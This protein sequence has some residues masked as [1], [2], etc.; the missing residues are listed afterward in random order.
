[1][2]CFPAR[3]LNVIN[4]GVYENENILNSKNIKEKLNT[5]NINKENANNQVA[6]NPDDIL[7]VNNNSPNSKTVKNNNSKS[8]EK[9]IEAESKNISQLR[10]FKV[11]NGIMV[12][13]LG[14][15]PFKFYEKLKVLGEGS[16]GTVFKV[17]HKPTGFIRAM[18]IIDKKSAALSDESEKTLINE[19]IILKSLDHPNI[20]KVNEYFNTK[21]K[22]YI[23]SELCTGGELFDKIQQEKIFTEK[24]AAHVMKQ[25]LSAVYYCHSN[26]V[27]HRDL[28]PE[29]ILIESEKEAKKE[30]FQ[31][32]IIDFGTSDVI[33]KN[34][35]LTKQIG[36][37]YYI[38][39]EILN[40]SYN[41]K[42]DLWSCGVILYIMLCGTPP[43][44][45]EDDED[46]YNLVK[47]GKYDLSG[48]EWSDVSTEAKDL[49]RNLLIKDIN[50]RFSAEQA[51]N[52]EWF[53][54]MESKI[55]LHNNQNPANKITDNKIL[56]VAKN[57]KVYKH[58]NKK[59]QQATLAYIVHNMLKKEETE[60]F[61]KI[62]LEFD[63]NG[64]GRLTKEELILGLSKVMTPEEAKNEVD[65]VM[66][67]IDVD[68]NGFIEYEEFLRAAM[69][70]ERILTEDNLKTVFNLFDKDHSGKISIAEIR[71]VLGGDV[72]IPDEIWTEI[73]C[74]IDKNGDGEISFKE[75]KEMMNKLVD[76]Q[77]LPRKAKQMMKGKLAF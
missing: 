57:L 15:D 38:A 51:L 49:I 43:F 64:D 13:N 25:V 68:G 42:C 22:L 65:K 75:F 26:K 14:A 4:D 70:K 60:E 31:I 2:G 39:P 20:I 33:R 36:T 56:R 10:D 52:H 3:K 58:A 67:L 61:R 44:F 72:Q 41:E 27:I 45:A 29:N 40:N 18:K 50:K 66:S 23:V 63:A 74:E 12:Q 7:N 8:N 55:K 24:V 9:N 47:A 21:R 16:F 32:K 6:N 62:F 30:F 77:K 1:M 28:K 17:I 34:T 35:M 73:V 59:L 37:P 5:S 48:S 69:N 54:K 11:T 71:N 76:N 46:I 53:K 19:I